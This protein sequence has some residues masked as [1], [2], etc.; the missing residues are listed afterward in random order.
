MKRSAQ[1]TRKTAETDIRVRLRLD[2]S[3]AC[4]AA[5]PIAFLNHMLD[6]TTRHGLFDLSVRAHGDIEVDYHHTVEDIGICLGQALCRALGDKRRIRRYGEAT[7]PMDESL[8][9]AVVDISGRPLLVLKTPPLRGRTGTF[10]LD[11]IAEFFQAFV[12]HAGITLHMDVL[13][14]KN[15]HHIIEALFK[16]FGRALSVAVSIDPRVKGVPSTKGTL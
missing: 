9:R 10:D 7:V 11:L 15:P 6:L 8:A 16:A 3:G 4:S 1:I 13:R 12:N 5:T 2:G 14:G